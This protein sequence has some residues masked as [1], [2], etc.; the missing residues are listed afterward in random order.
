[1][2]KKSPKIRTPAGRKLR[3]R[4]GFTIGEM[5]VCVLILLLCTGVISSTMAL[6][7]NQF[8]ARTRE[9]EAR[10]L[11]NALSLAVQDQLLY[12][13]SVTPVPSA[14]STGDVTLTSFVSG[15]EGMKGVTC[16]FKVVNNMLTLKYGVGS[17]EY[18]LPLVD[19]SVYSGGKDLRVQESDFS[20]TYDT[21]EGCFR[22]SITVDSTSQSIQSATNTFTVTPV[23]AGVL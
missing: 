9:S 17:K 18:Y 2:I 21:A 23:M 3:S 6:A 22:V 19:D 8:K 12:A 5:L 4:G 14:T 10:L 13:R 1:M 15:A 11:C 20:C 16:S 7:A